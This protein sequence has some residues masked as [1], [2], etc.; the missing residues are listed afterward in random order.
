MTPETEVLDLVLFSEAQS[1]VVVF[2][3]GG[4]A[5]VLDG[6]EQKVRAVATGLDVST[7][8]GRAEIRSLAFQ[9]RKTKTALDN[10]GKRLTEEWRKNTSKVNEERKKGQERLDALAEEVRAP[11]TAFEEKE[12]R[13]VAAHEEALRELG[14]LQVLIGPGGLLVEAPVS[15]LEEHLL[16]YSKFLVGRDWEEFHDRAMKVRRE[17]M[18]SLI[19]R[20][21]SRKR[22]EAEQAEL[23]RLRAAE[24]ERQR[25]EA[26]RLQ[27]ER[28]ERLQA[29]AAEAARVEA[30]RKA[31]EA[32][33]S[34]RRRV[35]DEAARV[36]REH[37]Q[38]LAQAEADRLA[39]QA[40]VEERRRKDEEKRLADLRAAEVLRQRE[41]QARFNA[42]REMEA[43][44]I[45]AQKDLEESQKKAADAARKASEKARK[46]REAAL[47]AERDRITAER[48]TADL[49]RRRREE[50][51][52]N[53]ARVR[54]EIV[55]DILACVQEKDFVGA[56][57]DLIMAGKVRNVRV[58]Y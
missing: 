56:V 40:R 41:E 1:S 38:Q 12:K 45:Q 9:V 55:D 51:E 29:E 21:E 27:R 53:K 17:V 31:A 2:T 23:A 50:D 8:T 10:E 54:A 49:E 35:A 13:R 30:E 46:D 28:E 5:A 32:A 16:D 7:E 36:Q 14:G 19:Q 3:G 58:E 20:I 33:E 43:L 48:V 34:E 47:Q 18:G 24:E 44:K 15:L 11:L 25:L 37:E 26:E 22:H 39:E 52:A 42:E 4:M 6:I 57:A